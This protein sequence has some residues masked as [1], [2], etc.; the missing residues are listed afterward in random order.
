MLLSILAAF[1]IVFGVS[2]EKGPCL[3]FDSTIA[4]L[5]TMTQGETKEV[6][7]HFKNTGSKALVIDHTKSS[8]GCT[9]AFSTRKMI[10]PDSG[11][12]VLVTFNSV[13]FRGEKTKYIY[14]YSNDSRHPIDTLTIHVFVLSEVDCT[15]RNILLSDPVKGKPMTETVTFFNPGTVPLAISALET[16]E[17]FIK[18]V[19]PSVISLK[20]GDSIAV[21]VIVTPPDSATS[22][23]GTIR[24]V[25][26]GGVTTH[27]FSIMVYGKYKK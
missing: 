26:K 6:P 20:P 27:P 24:V 1:G 19:L 25:T 10:S 23:R 14:I 11:G 9:S 18:P 22:F 13:Q 15:P 3:V 4:R 8:C 21:K 5:D 17:S 2:L 12:V 7:F 16:S